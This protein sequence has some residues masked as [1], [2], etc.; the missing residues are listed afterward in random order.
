[1][2]ENDQLRPDLDAA[3]D[4][5]VSSLTAVSD[6]AAAASLRRTRIALADAAP[7]RDGLGSWRWGLVA[8]AALIVLASAL[9]L[10][11]SRA[12]RPGSI[13][14]RRPANPAIVATPPA[15]S[16]PMV[17]PLPV[18]PQRVANAASPPRPAGRRRSVPV[19]ATSAAPTPPESSR[20]DPLVALV[21]AVQQIPEDAWQ[22]GTALASQPVSVPDVSFA[23]IDV[24][25]LE[26]PPI[27]DASVEPLAP[28][29]P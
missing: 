27:A 1:V 14:E 20:P 21:R 23:P 16:A 3:I 2:T 26:T 18:A 28:G 29:E 12:P 8:A 13:V 24:A 6:D 25:P 10:W 4:V 19:Q 5:A 9:V 15:P 7:A 11:R 22:R 17:A